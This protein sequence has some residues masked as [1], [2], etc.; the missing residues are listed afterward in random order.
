MG[1]VLS[2]MT[3]H[4][5]RIAVIATVCKNMLELKPELNVQTSLVTVMCCYPSHLLHLQQE[6][7]SSCCTLGSIPFSFST[8]Q[9]EVKLP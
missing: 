1:S 4:V 6:S 7:L 8:F 9:Y 2:L 5:R 3:G